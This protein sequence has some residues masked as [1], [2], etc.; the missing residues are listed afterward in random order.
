VQNNAYNVNIK[1][2]IYKVVWPSVSDSGSLTPL[3]SSYRSPQSRLWHIHG[4]SVD[5]F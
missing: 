1:C 3:L 2:W 5:K 4:V